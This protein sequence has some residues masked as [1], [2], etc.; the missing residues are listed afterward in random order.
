MQSSDLHAKTVTV[1][2]N[3]GG[4]FVSCMY[5][6]ICTECL[7]ASRKASAMSSGVRLPANLTTGATVTATENIFRDG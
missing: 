7:H 5:A 2:L 4:M 1:A 6:C 3:G